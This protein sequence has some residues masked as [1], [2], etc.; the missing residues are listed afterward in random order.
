MPLWALNIGRLITLDFP[1]FSFSLT[2]QIIT[3]YTLVTSFF[4]SLRSSNLFCS[5][6]NNKLLVK[7]ISRYCKDNIRFIYLFF[8]WPILLL[9]PLFTDDLQ[10]CGLWQGQSKAKVISIDEVPETQCRRLLSAEQMGLKMYLIHQ[11]RIELNRWKK[12]KVTD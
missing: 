12:R 2:Y 6:S 10:P 1:S 7:H 3:S 4:F 9:H 5:A 8:Y 11:L